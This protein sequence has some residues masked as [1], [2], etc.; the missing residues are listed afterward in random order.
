MNAIKHRRDF[1]LASAALAT[2]HAWAQPAAPQSAASLERVAPEL[3]ALGTM[4]KV[5]DVQLL[6]GQTFSMASQTASRVWVL[7]WWSSTCP[8]CAL[9]SPEMQKLWL[10]YK[11]RGLSMLTLSIDKKAAD[12]SAYLEKRRYSFPAAWVTPEFQKALPKP[13]GLPITL[14]CS[15]TGKLLQAERGQMFAE[16]VA[17]ISRWL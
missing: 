2:S 6:D 5:P 13:R 8:F 15:P 16:D 11:D 10:A 14:V 3:P 4:L 17:L 9:Q 7:Y 12:A 1:L